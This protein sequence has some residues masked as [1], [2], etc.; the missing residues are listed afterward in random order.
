[1][2]IIVYAPITEM[3]ALERDKDKIRRF[4][5][6]AEVQEGF[7]PYPITGPQVEEFKAGQ[8]LYITEIL[9]QSKDYSK[10][11]YD[12]KR[13]ILSYQSVLRLMDRG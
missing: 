13:R 1:M 3:E 2:S 5:K 6:L 8:V 9:P 11:V 10:S 12:G 7:D 4:F